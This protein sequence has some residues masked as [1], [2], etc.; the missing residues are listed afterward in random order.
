MIGLR[1]EARI[2]QIDDHVIDVPPSDHMLIVR[3]DDRPGVIG[4]V[5]TVLGEAGV[6]IDNMDVG[7]SWEENS[8]MMVLAVTEPVAPSVVAALRESDG[9]LSVDVIDIA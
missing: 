3:N 9:V 6:N 1:D 7:R 2:I 5:G 4:I 8:A